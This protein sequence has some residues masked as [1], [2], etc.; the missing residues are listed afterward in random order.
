[1]QLGAR[2]VVIFSVSKVYQIIENPQFEVVIIV[3]LG[4]E[5]GPILKAASGQFCRVVS[6]EVESVKEVGVLGQG[7]LFSR[8][9]KEDEHMFGVFDA[10]GYQPRAQRISSA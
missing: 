6:I 8:L 1:M 4:V 2:V 5:T 7:I 3:Q 10:R 9:L